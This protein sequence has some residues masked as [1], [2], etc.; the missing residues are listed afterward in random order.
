[1]D[2]PGKGRTLIEKFE[3]EARDAVFA[4]A[5][6]TPDDVIKT[7]KVEYIQPRPNVIFELGCSMHALTEN[8][9]ASFYA[10]ELIYIQISMGYRALSFNVPSRK[11]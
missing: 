2:E 1:M 9:Y 7:E 4:F 6:L 8:V 10:R 3:E 5:L 11:K